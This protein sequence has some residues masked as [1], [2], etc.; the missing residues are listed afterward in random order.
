VSRRGHFDRPVAVGR[1]LPGESFVMLAG[2]AN[3]DFDDANSQCCA[4]ARSAPEEEER[5]GGVVHAGREIGNCPSY[6]VEHLW[7]LDPGLD[8]G[9][10]NLPVDLVVEVEGLERSL[11]AVAA[12]RSPDCALGLV[13]DLVLAGRQYTSYEETV[14]GHT[15][16]DEGLGERVVQM[17]EVR[18]CWER[19]ESPAEL[20]IQPV[21]LDFVD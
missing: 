17:S 15:G 8:P 7:E 3:R 2:V 4:P 11:E 18:T 16:K 10:E 1:R 9:T 6:S 5:R 21:V 12:G 20:E 14:R 19:C 13:A